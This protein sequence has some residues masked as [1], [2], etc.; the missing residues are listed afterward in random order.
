MAFQRLAALKGACA[1]IITIEFSLIVLQPLVKQLTELPD[2]ERMGE[3]NE[4]TDYGGLNIPARRV[5]KGNKPIIIVE[6]IQKKAY[7]GVEFSCFRISIDQKDQDQK[8]NNGCYGHPID[9]VEKRITGKGHV[10]VFELHEEMACMGHIQHHED[11]R[12]VEDSLLAFQICDDL[13]HS[14]ALQGDRKW[15]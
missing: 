6:E 13:I 5:L 1:A 11:K 9:P 15:I 4:N 14:F 10:E 2:R 12:P 7:N 3:A 8:L